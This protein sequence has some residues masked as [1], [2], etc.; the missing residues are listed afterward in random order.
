MKEAIH[1]RYALLPYFY[2]LFREA[3]T[4]GVPVMRPLWMEFPA[5]EA[6][7]SN[8]EAFM[9]GSS[10]LVQGVFTER[11]KHAS[12]Y[13]PSGQS[14]YYLN[15]GTAYKGGRTHKMEVSEES[16]PAFQ[17][18]GTIIPRKDRFRRS[19]TQMENDPYTLV[20]A[21]NSTQEAEGELYIDDG[22]SFE[23]AKGA[24]LHRRFVFSNG[25]LTSSNAAPSASG[26]SQFSSDCV[27]ER[28]ILL[29]YSPGP[30]STRIEPANQ[31]AEIELGPLYLRNGRSPTV[32]TIRKPNV[33]IADDWMIQVL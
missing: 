26:K 11:A 22:K 23:F 12:V 3:N 2:T 8:D 33:R 21:L 7:F 32:F 14:W 18:A 6:T 20:I 25:K 10:L 5:D 28:I 16:I 19:S 13:L 31:K 27:V 17:R 1:V 9:V 30:K 15:S 4:S 29:G 24:Y